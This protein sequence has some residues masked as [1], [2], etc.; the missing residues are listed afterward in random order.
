MIFLDLNKFSFVLL[1]LTILLFLIIIDIV[2]DILNNYVIFI[3]E[4]RS[5][6]ILLKS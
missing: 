3:T 6:A 1:L 4:I 2:I 5:R